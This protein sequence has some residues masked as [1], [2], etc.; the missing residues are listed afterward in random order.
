M[1]TQFSSLC[2]QHSAFVMGF[3]CPTVTS[4]GFVSIQPI[5]GKP[6]PDAGVEG[7]VRSL[8]VE[9]HVLEGALHSFLS[10]FRWP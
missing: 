1:H 6:L 9:V 2:G 4:W 8:D 10:N 7:P 5:W 3:S